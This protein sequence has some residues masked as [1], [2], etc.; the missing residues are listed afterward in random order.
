MLVRRLLDVRVHLHAPR[1]SEIALAH[2]DDP[3]GD[4]RGGLPR[5][6]MGPKKRAMG[7]IRQM[8]KKDFREVAVRKACD[9]FAVISY[10]E[11]AASVALLRSGSC[12]LCKHGDHNHE[13]REHQPRLFPHRVNAENLARGCPIVRMPNAVRPMDPS[14][15][16][17]LSLRSP[18]SRSRSARSRRRSPDLP[19][20]PAPPGTSPATAASRPLAA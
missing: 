12:A 15:R 3:A 2:A 9:P 20:V 18:P 6:D 10:C 11:C 4:L 1:L 14:R 17:G 5:R 16:A 8:S 19:A 13:P 7:A